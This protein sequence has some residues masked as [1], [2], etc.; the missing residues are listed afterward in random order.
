M[1]VPRDSKL[2]REILYFGGAIP[3][4]AGA[5]RPPIAG[6]ESDPTVA[7]EFSCNDDLT[8]TVEH[9]AMTNSICFF[10]STFN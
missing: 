10:V 7:F 2:M 1:Q 3:Q 6:V 5:Y 8:A 9:T 4:E